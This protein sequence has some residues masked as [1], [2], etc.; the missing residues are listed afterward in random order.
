MR[1]HSGVWNR[2][3]KVKR[4]RGYRVYGAD[5]SRYIDFYL[6]GGRA[7]A[8]HR[9]GGA[10]Q[11]L[12]STA[13][14]GLWAEYPGKWRRR[15]DQL[16]TQLYS[17]VADITYFPSIE[18]ALEALRALQ[19]SPVRI[20]DTP[21]ELHSGEPSGS[22]DGVLLYR[23]WALDA[24]QQ[25][26]LNE[27]RYGRFFIPLIPF[28]GSFLPVPVCRLQV[29]SVSSGDSAEPYEQHELSPVLFHLLIKSLA[30][31]Q[32]LLQQNFASMWCRFDLPGIKRVG[33]YLQFEFGAD[34][35]S[36]FYHE[37]LEKG[38]LL[39]PSQETPAVIPAEFT[40]GEVL[41]LI[42]GCKEMSWKR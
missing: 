37:M 36:R 33:P 9:P 39:P 23:P 20:I 3:P 6:N 28:P 11:V 32:H 31:L 14:R 25:R 27:G 42:K 34:E 29:H 22:M 17:G 13:E 8:G 24:E 2:L 18:H 26:R 5:G 1:V 38:V 15:A 19:G 21:F 35:Y 4:A 12:K 40:D 30:D 16:L 10:L 41:P 7:L